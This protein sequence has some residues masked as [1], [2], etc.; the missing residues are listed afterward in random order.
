MLYRR[1]LTIAGLALSLL[2]V[3]PTAYPAAAQDIRDFDIVNMSSARIDSVYVAPSASNTW[4][5]NILSAQV[6]PGETLM[7]RFNNPQPGLC[8]YDLYTSYTDGSTAQLDELNVCQV[9]K[10]FVDDTHIWAE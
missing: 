4:G 10:V 6:Q 1:A 3:A 7:V 9:A 5:S 2:V 8:I